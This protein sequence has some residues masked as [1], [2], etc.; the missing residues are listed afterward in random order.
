MIFR[1]ALRDSFL[2]AWSSK[3]NT[4][5]LRRPATDDQPLV[6][7]LYSHEKRALNAAAGL[8]FAGAQALLFF[9]FPARLKRLLKNSSTASP[10]AAEGFF[11]NLIA[12]SQRLFVLC[13]DLIGP[14]QR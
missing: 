10:V 3:P 6:A 7:T 14:L 13:G 12:P 1:L 9:I 11:C 8:K 2:A 5:V 4:Q